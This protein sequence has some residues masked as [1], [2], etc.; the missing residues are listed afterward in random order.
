MNGL[1]VPPFAAL[2]AHIGD[3]RVA[4]YMGLKIKMTKGR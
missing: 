3:L 1:P 4:S 2:T